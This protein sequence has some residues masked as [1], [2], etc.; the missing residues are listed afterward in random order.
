MPNYNYVID[1]SYKPYSLQ[2]MLMPLEA[3]KE[4]YD[5][6]EEKYLTLNKGASAFDYLASTLPEDS[7]ARQIYQNYADDLAAQAKDFETNGLNISNGSALTSLRRRYDNEI[8]KLERADVV[9]KEI[10]KNMRDKG[11]S[12]LWGNEAPSLDDILHNPN[13][14]NYGISI[15][16][17]YKRGAQAATSAST[18]VYNIPKVQE[19]TNHYQELIQAQGYSPKV[20][21]AFRKDLEAI[22]E[23]NAAINNIMI[24]TGAEDNLSGRTYDRA[25]QSIINGLID[26]AGAAYKET[27]TIKDNPDSMTAYQRAQLNQNQMELKLR[28]FENGY[29][30]NK[31]TGEY[32]LDPNIIRD[33]LAIYDGKLPPGF[34]IDP[35]NPN[36]IIKEPSS[37]SMSAEEKAEKER[38]KKEEEFN[39]KVN[40]AKQNALL[41]P[42]MQGSLLA[43]NKGFD[44]TYG[45]KDGIPKNR[46]HY[47]YIGALAN[48]GGKWRHGS[49]G[50][51]VPGHGWGM[52]SS[53]N[54][55]TMRGNFSAEGSDSKEKMR[56]LSENE[57]NERLSSDA[58]LREA[59]LAQ[60]EKAGY[61]IDDDLDY[62]LIEVPNEWDSD[63]VGYL[64][65]IQK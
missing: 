25:R 10:Q 15:E 37:S 62:E 40:I 49:I 32:E 44:L 30:Y 39:K 36:K 1:S 8:G 61:S 34:M 11:S 29:K 26:G 31:E 38:Q 52:F 28:A 48:S 14:T 64:I 65:A 58:N 22:P 50:D 54:V 16:D 5:K 43:N 3:Y 53:S 56:I 27:R 46:V 18:G 57:V 63:K 47:D 21:E 9:L 13:Y 45:G 7:E 17:L 60:I 35:N 23:F 19:I 42:E 4:A 59:L 55:E 51:D 6:A 41:D 20:I 24:E 33:K 12:Y 2:E